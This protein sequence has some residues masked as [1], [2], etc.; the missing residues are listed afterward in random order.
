M[1]KIYNSAYFRS[2][3]YLVIGVAIA[4]PASALVFRYSDDDIKILQLQITKLD[5]E[6]EL[7]KLNVRPI[8]L[9]NIAG[10]VIKQASTTANYFGGN[11]KT[12]DS[13]RTAT[14]V[15]LTVVNAYEADQILVGITN[16]GTTTFNGC[17]P[18]TCPGNIYLNPQVSYDASTWYNWSPLV[19]GSGS[20]VN[21]VNLSSASSTPFVVASPGNGTLTISFTF[22]NI[23]AKYMRFQVWTSGTSTILL[24]GFTKVKN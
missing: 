9:G 12:T 19:A 13:L 16:T 5:K 14:T 23:V 24:E 3:I 15:L 18:A 4:Y 8:T 7:L 17:T 11:D 2:F 22:D 1:E 10:D 21:N 6:I 20:A